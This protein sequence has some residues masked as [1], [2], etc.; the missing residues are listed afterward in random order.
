MAEDHNSYV[1]AD[2]YDEDDFDEPE[3]ECYGWFEEGSGRFVCGAV[4]SEDC[5]CCPCYNWLG[6]TSD[7]VDE[8]EEPT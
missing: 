5:D 7:E 4:G 6:L 2:D 8:L 3:D 1:Y